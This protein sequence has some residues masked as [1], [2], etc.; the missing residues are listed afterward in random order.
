MCETDG[1]KYVQNTVICLPMDIK[2]CCAKG[3][4]LTKAIVTYKHDY[5]NEENGGG[6]YIQWDPCHLL[7]RMIPAYQL[8][9]MAKERPVEVHI[10][11]DGAM[12]SKN[13]NHWTVGT[14]QGETLHSVPNANN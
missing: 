3:D 14:K 1:K 13:W 5:L 8:T 10:A 4:T 6:E 9:S 7:A 2:C 12:L 11:I